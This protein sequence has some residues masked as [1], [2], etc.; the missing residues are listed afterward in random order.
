LIFLSSE[1]TRLFALFCYL[2]V[3]FFFRVRAHVF[4]LTL[5]LLSCALVLFICAKLRKDTNAL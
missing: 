4:H 2:A 3:R 1:L 5:P